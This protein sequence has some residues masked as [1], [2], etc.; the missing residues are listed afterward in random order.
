M[1]RKVCVIGFDGATFDLIEPFMKRGLL[2]H[3][4]K[5]LDEGSSASLISV[6]PP[7]SAPAWVSLV[8]GK[9]P[10]IHNIYGSPMARGE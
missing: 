5:L 7:V 1:E 8:T 2:P 6:I 10:G 3:F 4:Q 9:N